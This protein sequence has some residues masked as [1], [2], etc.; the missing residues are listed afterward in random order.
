M[1][2]RKNSPVKLKSF[3][4]TANAPI[5]VDEPENYW[6]L[7][8]QSAIVVDDDL[9]DSKK[10]LIQFK[11]DL[12]EFKLENHNPIKNTLRISK[13]DLELDRFEIY[14]QKLG[15]EISLRTS[16]MNNTKWYRIFSR[17]RLDK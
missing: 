15:K 8:G 12:D 9:S 7:I 17:L 3:L 14:N 10:V 5:S 16:Y 4:G 6:K 2:I 1:K 13:S 11:S